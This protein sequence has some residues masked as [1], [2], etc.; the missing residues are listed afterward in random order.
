VPARYPR[1][2]CRRR[3][4]RHRRRGTATA[5]VTLVNANSE[6]ARSIKP[7]EF[8]HS[9]QLVLPLAIDAGLFF[10]LQAREIVR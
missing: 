6:T 8:L 9:S 2:R 3:R 5:V 4:R 1:A 10:G 7:S